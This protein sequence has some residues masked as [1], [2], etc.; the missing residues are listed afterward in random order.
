MDLTEDRDGL[1][2]LSDTELK[3]QKAECFFGECDI[4]ASFGFEVE[5]PFGTSEP[6]GFIISESTV[7]VG[8]SSA[9]KQNLLDRACSHFWS[10]WLASTG[11]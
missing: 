10:L 4:S 9:S 1:D 3:V 5:L 11:L 2:G 8:L 7:A 6:I